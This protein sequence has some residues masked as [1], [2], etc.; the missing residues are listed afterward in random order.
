MTSGMKRPSPRLLALSFVGFVGVVSLLAFQATSRADA[1]H[2]RDPG[3]SRFEPA[4]ASQR[5]GPTWVPEVV[6]A[7][8][9]PVQC[10][11]GTWTRTAVR[12]GCARHAG[13]AH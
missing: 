1:L 13:V 9:L 11:D 5:L 6:T 8:G 4:S 2:P 12:A 10:G 3:Q 7:P